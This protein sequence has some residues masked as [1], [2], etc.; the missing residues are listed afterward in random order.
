MVYNADGRDHGQW[1][2]FGIFRIYPKAGSLGSTI[3]FERI[4]LLPVFGPSVVGSTQA[5]LSLLPVLEH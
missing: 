4:C 2:S 1:D 3:S 5:L